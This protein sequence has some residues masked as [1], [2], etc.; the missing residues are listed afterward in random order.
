MLRKAV[1]LI[2]LLTSVGF[3]RAVCI[4][5][6]TNGPTQTVSIASVDTN[7]VPVAGVVYSVPPPN[8]YSNDWR[9]EPGPAHLH[10]GLAWSTANEFVFRTALRERYKLPGGSSIWNTNGTAVISFS[11]L[12]GKGEIRLL[13]RERTVEIIPQI[14]PSSPTK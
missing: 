1:R 3:V 2:G 8:L 13:V 6:N 11:P 9:T 12:R 4:A 7:R 5:A 14:E 10:L